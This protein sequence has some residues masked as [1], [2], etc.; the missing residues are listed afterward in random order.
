[1]KLQQAMKWVSTYIGKSEEVD[2]GI[3]AADE[4]RVFIDILR[5]IEAKG[6]LDQVEG[7][8][9]SN[10]CTTQGNITI[11]VKNLILLAKL[12]LVSRLF[13][14]LAKVVNKTASYIRPKFVNMIATV[15]EIEVLVYE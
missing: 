7:N 8:L 1:M 3:V 9:A 13:D 6:V 15:T 11:Y 10:C 2:A 12:G 5:K 14:I 4:Y